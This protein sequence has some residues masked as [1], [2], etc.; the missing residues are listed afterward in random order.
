MSLLEEFIVTTSAS[1][2]KIFS[3]TTATV[4]ENWNEEYPGMVRVEMFLGESGKNWTGWIPVMS[5]YAGNSHGYYALPEVESEV[6]VAFNMGDRNCPIVIGS[7]WSDK[8][9]LPADTAAKDN[10][11][12][13]FKTKGGCEIIFSDED[14]KQNIEIKTPGGFG[15]TIDDENK[16][17]ELHD[18]SGKNGL[19]I[20]EKNGAVAIKA[21][22][23]VTLSV[24]GSDVITLDAQSAAV[25]SQSVKLEAD[26]NLSL[27]GMNDTI[28]GSQ[29][30]VSANGT[31]EVSASGMTQIKGSMVK[32]N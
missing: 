13:R 11:V 10:L 20:D 21:D 12:K 4:K 25:K 14:S 32:I 31:M 27:K 15:I 5:M 29:V 3:V 1:E 30:K 2:D 17:V 23:K 26:Q 16:K 6:V 22:K 18:S 28:E 7:L 19:L 24:G 9:A 8:N